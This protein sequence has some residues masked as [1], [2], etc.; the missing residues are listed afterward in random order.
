MMSLSCLDNL[1]LF[2]ITAWLRN[3]TLSE[4]E[5]NP[6]SVTTS[7]S[8]V[9]WWAA[10]RRFLVTHGPCYTQLNRTWYIITIAMGDFFLFLLWMLLRLQ[11]FSPSKYVLLKS[12]L[13]NLLHFWWTLVNGGIRSIYIVK[14]KT[15]NLSFAIRL[16]RRALRL[17]R[18]VAVTEVMHYTQRGRKDRRGTD[19]SRGYCYRTNCNEGRWREWERDWGCSCLEREIEREWERRDIWYRRKI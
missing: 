11:Y 14:A 15:P 7:I 17:V 5:T 18:L 10:R 16:A 9:C 3:K 19:L 1:S 8:F 13:L 4:Y 6:L 12:D 2:V